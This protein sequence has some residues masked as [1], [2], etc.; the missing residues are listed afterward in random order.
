[1]VELQ[2]ARRISPVLNGMSG[3]LRLRLEVELPGPRLLEPVGTICHLTGQTR[4]WLVSRTKNRWAGGKRRRP[5]RRGEERSG[6]SDAVSSLLPHRGTK[7]E[8]PLLRRAQ[9]SGSIASDNPPTV[10][11]HSL[12]R[13]GARRRGLGRNEVLRAEGG[14]SHKV[15]EDRNGEGA[16]A[17]LRLISGP[18]R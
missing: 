2:T 12:G 14:R 9:L 8:P 5:S 11:S 3:V 7:T 13:L 6:G 18:N 15:R 1:M 4:P 17:K 10:V 16:G